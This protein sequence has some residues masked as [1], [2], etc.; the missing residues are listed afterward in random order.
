MIYPILGMRAGILYQRSWHKWLI[1]FYTALLL[2]ALSI[3]TFADM[4]LYRH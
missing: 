3:I 2:F 4:E 1:H